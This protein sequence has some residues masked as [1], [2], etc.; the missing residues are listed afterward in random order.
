MSTITSLW[1]NTPTARLSRRD[2]DAF[3]DV[4]A[5]LA[6]KFIAFTD[7]LSDVSERTG[8]SASADVLRL[9]EKWLRTRSPRDGQRL[10]DAGH[11]AQLVDRVQIPPI[12][13]SQLGRAVA[14]RP[15]RAVV[16]HPRLHR[17]LF[18]GRDLRTKTGVSGV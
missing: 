5:E 7:V 12:A 9:Y 3:G 16:P 1:V 4:F 6:G 10:V 17:V 11:P 18:A 14:D 2:E 8:M 15:Q 13:S